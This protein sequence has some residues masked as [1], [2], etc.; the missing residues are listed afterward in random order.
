MGLVRA[1][2]QRSTYVEDEDVDPAH[3]SELHVST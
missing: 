2:V 3:T 1:V